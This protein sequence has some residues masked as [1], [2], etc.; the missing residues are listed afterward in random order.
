MLR[1][2]VVAQSISR[3]SL[4]DQGSHAGAAAERRSI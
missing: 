3:P 4:V 2:C 1:K